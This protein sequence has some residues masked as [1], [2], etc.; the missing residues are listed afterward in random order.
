MN[1]QAASVL[2]KFAT[3]TEEELEAIFKD[4]SMN[5]NLN[6]VF[7]E[8]HNSDL[9]ARVVKLA[10]PS[11]GA[12]AQALMVNSTDT[13]LRLRMMKTIIGIAT[14]IKEHDGFEMVAMT[15]FTMGL[16]LALILAPQTEV[17][18]EV[19]TEVQA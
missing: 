2:K 9:I 15:A 7:G 8:G 6:E 18:A 1:E 16:Q 11:A 4:G 12:T 17:A 14:G 3:L 10:I 19:A 13:A 5:V